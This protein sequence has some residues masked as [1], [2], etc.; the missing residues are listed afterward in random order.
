MTASLLD[1]AVLE[2]FLGS[3]LVDLL[4]D[5]A[6]SELYCNDDLVLRTDGRGG[7]RDTGIRLSEVKL[8]S[9]FQAIAVAAGRELDDLH[10]IGDFQLP[11]ELGAGR[12]HVKIPPVVSTLAFNIRKPATRLLLLDELIELG[13]L[14]LAEATCLR[15]A[16]A[17]KDSILVVGPTNSGKTNLLNA[18]LHVSIA[19]HPGNTRYVVLEDVPEIVCP[20]AD[21]S[22]ARTTPT[23]T[24]WDLVRATMRS[25]PDFIVVGEIRGN[26]AFPFLDLAASG[27]GGVLAS[28]HADTP[29]GALNR[30]NRLARR[31]DPDVPD[32]HELIAEVVQTVVC[33]T[34]G[35]LGRRVSA[36]ARIK[37]WN[38]MSGYALDWPVP[39]DG[40]GEAQ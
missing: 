21:V 17:K 1:P 14:T 2:A 40:R 4:S 35:S 28:I 37:G 36:I 20:A 6:I 13:T 38:R 9:F 22:Y 3:Y 32:Q 11:R 26:E 39:Q 8:R 10:P 27:H 12:L 30:L 24:L 31:N 15:E 18:L 33:L 16:I 19:T 25:S 29:L 34:G 5:P 7:R 23:V